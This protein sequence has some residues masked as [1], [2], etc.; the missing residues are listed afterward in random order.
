MKVL[1]AGSWHDSNESEYSVQFDS[2]SVPAVMVQP[3]VLRC[4]APRQ[5]NTAT[6]IVSLSDPRLSLTVSLSLTIVS[7]CLTV[8]LSDPRLSL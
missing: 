8:S 6:T 1:V 3:G 7:L 5:Y 2:V 4:Y